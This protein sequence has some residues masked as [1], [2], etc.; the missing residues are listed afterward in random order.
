VLPNNLSYIKFGYYFDQPLKPGVFPESLKKIQFGKTFD[1]P[2]EPGVL[3][4]YLEYL[5]FRQ[6]HTYFGTE[7]GHFNHP[8]SLDALPSSLKRIE[9]PNRGYTH[10]L[11]RAIRHLI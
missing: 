10:S 9:L 2:I 1:E 4:N 8:L 3:P 6:S 11:P 7:N 5:C